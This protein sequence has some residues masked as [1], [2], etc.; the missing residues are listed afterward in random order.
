MVVGL[1]VM[2]GDG[3]VTLGRSEESKS[4]QGSGVGLLWP[5][6]FSVIMSE[7]TFS[8][9]GTFPIRLRSLVYNIQD[10]I[11]PFFRVEVFPPIPQIC[12]EPQTGGHFSD[13]HWLPLQ[14][15]AD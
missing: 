8:F 14:A 13:S 10:F 3:K 9:S 7:A 2:K 12:N 5:L 1:K 6:V 4:S 11:R 15:L